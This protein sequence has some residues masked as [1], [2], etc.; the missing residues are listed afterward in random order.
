MLE[1]LERLGELP[2]D[3]EPKY[4]SLIEGQ[5]LRPARF[6]ASYSEHFPQSGYHPQYCDEDPLYTRY[7]QIDYL[8][9]YH[10]T[11]KNEYI[12]SMAIK[13][14]ADT[15]AKLKERT[16]PY[17]HFISLWEW[18]EEEDEL[19][20]PYFFFCGSDIEYIADTLIISQRLSA[21][22]TLEL[23]DKL[24]NDW[25]DKI[26]Q[27]FED[28][29]TQPGMIRLLIDFELPGQNSKKVT[30]QSAYEMTTGEG[31]MSMQIRELIDN[32][33]TQIKQSYRPVK[34]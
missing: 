33:L 29:K 30:L 19:P 32:N 18:E 31:K 28:R 14:W 16:D 6:N 3:L 20:C 10:P 15:E 13:L 24:H 23:Q 27:V 7:S 4:L 9:N 25:G 8:L 5:G 22:W 34:S 2:K 11:L 21:K 17:M 1:R 26:V 12:I